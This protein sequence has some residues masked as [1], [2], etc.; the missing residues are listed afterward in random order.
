MSE[1]LELLS[2]FIAWWYPIV[3]LAGAVVCIVFRRLS[4]RL[5]FLAFAFVFVGICE[6]MMHG[7]FFLIR[8]EVIAEEFH[9]FAS[10]VDSVL[11]VFGALLLVIGLA[12]T[13]SHVKHRMGLGS[14]RKKDIE[15]VTEQ[16]FPEEAAERWDSRRRG[17]RDIQQ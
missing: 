1:T 14:Q 10:V 4:P 6:G 2:E 16:K 9:P 13:L 11:D 3:M 7:L 8:Q 15:G 5:W 12:C 17:S